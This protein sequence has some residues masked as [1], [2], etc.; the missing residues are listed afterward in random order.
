MQCVQGLVNLAPNG[1]DDGGLIVMEGSTKLLD[2][3]F[4][5][6]RTGYAHEDAHHQ[7][8]ISVSTYPKNFLNDD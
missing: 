5:V 3:Y 8:R 1:P 2:E 7:R 6:L 4:K